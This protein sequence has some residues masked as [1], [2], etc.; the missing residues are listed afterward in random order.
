MQRLLFIIA[1]ILVLTPL[2]WGVARSIQ[3]SMPL[4]TAGA[5]TPVPQVGPTTL[6]HPN[7]SSKP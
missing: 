7:A 4:F 2:G 5:P 6:I 3:R 1:W